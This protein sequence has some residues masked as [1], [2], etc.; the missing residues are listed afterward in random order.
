M[1]LNKCNGSMEFLQ[2]EIFISSTFHKLLKIRGGG[3]SLAASTE[4]IWTFI[5]VYKYGI[6]ETIDD[7]YPSL[8][9]RP[10]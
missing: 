2:G 1:R 6:T 8:L 9:S 10:D 4:W 5:G 7:L 3:S